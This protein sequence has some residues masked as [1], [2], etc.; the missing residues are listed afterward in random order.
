MKKL[1][2]Q[3][4]NVYKKPIKNNILLMENINKIMKMIFS[5]Y[6]IEQ[7]SHLNLWLDK[8]KNHI[9][10]ELNLTAYYQLKNLIN[11]QH[12]KLRD[13]YYDSEQ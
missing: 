8:L 13:R 9:H 11:M 2:K 3:L 12:F 1:I 5:C 6:N 10:D 7:L 4:L